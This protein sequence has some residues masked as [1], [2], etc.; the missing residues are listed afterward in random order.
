MVSA[1]GGL[2]QAL[3]TLELDPSGAPVTGWTRAHHEFVADHSLLALRPWASA[4]HARFALP[5]P[6]SNAGPASDGLEAFARSFLAVGF[7][8]GTGIDDPHDHAGFYAAG[9]T[10]G[11]DPASAERWP[12]M[13]EVRQARVEAAAIAIALHESRRWIWDRL[14]PGV[15][16]RLVDWLSEAIGGDY[17]DNNWRWFANVTQAFL[18][19]VGGPHDASETSE[20]LEFLDGCYLGDGWYSD[21]RPGG[22]TGNVDWYNAW[23]MHLFSL[24]YCRILG[25]QAP[26]GLLER[27]RSRLAA[28]LPSGAR[29]F[30]DNGAPLF[31]GRSL[32]YRFAATA[33]FWAGPIFEVDTLAPGVVRRL[34]SGA[35][36]YFVEQDC[37]DENDLLSLGWHGRFEPMRQGY[38]GPGSPYWADL[39]FAGLLLG[40]DHPVWTEPE[41]ELPDADG[42]RPATPPGWLVGRHDGLARV[43]NHGTDHCGPEPRPED[44]QYCRFGYS[45]ATAPVPL[46]VGE[47]GSEAPPDNQVTLRDGRGRWSH[48]RPIE[49]LTISGDTAISRHVAHFVEPGHVDEPGEPRESGSTEL[50]QPGPE[51]VVGSVLRGPIEVR[52]VR[53][54]P[55][56]PSCRLFISG[57]AVPRGDPALAHDVRPLLGDLI[58]G[59]SVHS[60]ANPFGDHLDVAWAATPGILNTG[61]L[62]AVGV[63]LQA[64]DAAEVSWPTLSRTGST[65]QICWPDGTRQDLTLDG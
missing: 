58:T 18:R 21:G 16:E 29:L 62:Y 54:G 24:W 15:Q 64:S 60:L 52:A 25:D 14:D 19:S 33:A 30:G 31:Q 20:N 46:S 50:Q 57:F 53:V 34:G 13:T 22:R 47:P 41:A 56:G 37:Y 26:P 10:A 38:S 7:R 42:V 11:T 63:A 43:V 27:Y 51:I 49:L 59:R 65:L 8:L 32:V 28:F 35:L 55:G 40:P 44:P 9:L 61:E 5:G 1:D 2:R 3:G 45:T 6:V 17:G 36:R 12:R 23:V 39:G 4:G 48:R